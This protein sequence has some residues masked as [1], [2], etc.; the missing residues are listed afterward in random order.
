MG[1]SNSN[2]LRLAVTIGLGNRGI[3]VSCICS[4]LLVSRRYDDIGVLSAVCMPG[5][6]EGIL[7]KQEIYAYY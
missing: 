2:A 5:G 7:H 6:H 3:G 1:N 4:C